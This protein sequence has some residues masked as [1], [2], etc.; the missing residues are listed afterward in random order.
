MCTHKRII[1]IQLN[2]TK[3][4]KEMFW[5]NGCSQEDVSRIIQSDYET[6]GF[7]CLS[8]VE[9]VMDKIG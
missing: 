6:N 2:R 8:Y 9:D 4:R 7:A 5:I 3:E 1:R